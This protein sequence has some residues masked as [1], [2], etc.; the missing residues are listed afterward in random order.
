LKI[1]DKL[2]L[3]VKAVTDHALSKGWKL[4][5]A[6]MAGTGS[7]YV[8]LSRRRKERGEWVVIRVADHNQVYPGYIK[9]YSISPSELTFRYVRRLLS[10][11]FGRVGDVLL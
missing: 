11:P 9:T 2:P 3:I 5:E 10:K 6:K 4:E 1:K 8:E 7:C